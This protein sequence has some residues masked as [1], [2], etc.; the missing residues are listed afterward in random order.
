M[1]DTIEIDIQPISS[2]VLVSTNPQTSNTDLIPPLQPNKL[3]IVPQWGQ[4]L[5]T[6][7]QHMATEIRN[8]RLQIQGDN[9]E[10]YCIFM[11][12]QNNY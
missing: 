4:T 5:I 10:A 11:G 3:N 7:L 8:L 1:P 9:T 6:Q 12:I 2:G